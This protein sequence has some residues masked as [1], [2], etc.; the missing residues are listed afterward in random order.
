MISMLAVIA[1]I[2]L[3]VLCWG[4][5]G[6]LLH[7]GQ[8]FMGG[9]RLRP[10]VCVGVAYFIVAIVAPL[11]ILRLRGEKG[12]WTHSGIV[13]SL[14][15]GALGAVGALGIIMALTFGGHPSYVMP[16]VFGGAPVINSIVT[17]YMAKTF[18]QIGPLFYAGLILVIAGSVTV[19]TFKPKPGPAETAHAAE[20]HAQSEQASAA[21]AAP[22]RQTHLLRVIASTLLTVFAWGT[23][24][25]MLHKG[26]AKMQG[27][28]LRPL[29]CVGLS[30]L[31]IA[32]VVPALILGTAGE[33]GNFTFSGSVW[34]LIAGC[35]GA[36][37]ALG[38]ILAFTF[39][40]KPVYVMPLVFGGAPV[41]NT[42]TTLAAHNLFDDAGPI[43]YAGLIVT[44]AGAAV[45][46]VTAPKG[47]PPQ[48]K[49]A[50]APQPAKTPA[51]EGAAAKS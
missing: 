9:S 7:E 13:W 25:S 39:G 42:F 31:G 27:S 3:T 35:A 45:V 51:T 21:A 12:G 2:G 28:R 15:A 44:I 6:P 26:Q 11:I 48:A 40:G 17:I 49:A 34:S 16:L 36:F 8:H 37:G 4:N 47:K 19:L 33:P 50:G 41:V 5:Y 14:T 1:S 38:I 29:V 23:Y 22:P 46:L 32:V 18:N 20:E 24:G 43:F 30:Y 10:F